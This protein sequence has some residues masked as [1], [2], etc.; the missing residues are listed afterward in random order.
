MQHLETGNLQPIRHLG[1]HTPMSL[2]L[3]IR[4]PAR[5]SRLRQYFFKAEHFI[6][7]LGEER[8]MQGGAC[9][10]RCPRES[11]E[12]AA[13]TEEEVG[14]S[15]KRV[16]L[17]R[18]RSEDGQILRGVYG[19]PKRECRAVLWSRLHNWSRYRQQL[20][21]TRSA[22]RRLYRGAQLQRGLWI[23]MAAA[24]EAQAEIPFILN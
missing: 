7:A 23:H 17:A 14:V 12:I 10:S 16:T 4:R 18:E 24:P 19:E 8:E 22:G 13:W 1:A 2:W 5:L 9:V 21:A 15:L 20:V 3:R 6:A 11:V